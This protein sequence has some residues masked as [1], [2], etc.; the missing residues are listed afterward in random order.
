[1][2]LAKRLPAVFLIGSCTYSCIEILWRGFTHWTMGVTGGTCFCILYHLYTK[3]ERL[4]LFKKCAI[5]SAVITT[6][7]FVVGC[8]VN[9]QLHW[10]VWD[11]SSR[12]LNLFGQICPLYT[13]LWFLLSIPI[14]GVTTFLNRSIFIP[15]RRHF[16]LP[17]SRQ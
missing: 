15:R 6:A 1:M 12:P 17:A 10:N 7:E 11:Y 8:I 5:G 16:L 4:S 14:Y 13:I 9:L 2:K 3:F